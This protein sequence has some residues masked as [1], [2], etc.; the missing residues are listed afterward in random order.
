MVTKHIESPMMPTKHAK[1][2]LIA[3]GGFA[4]TGKTTIARRL[5]AD[6]GFPRLGSDDLGRM[7]G[8]SEG[9]RDASAVDAYWIAYDVLFSLCEEF[10][11][12]GV[13]T[14][15]DITL[16]WAF[17]WQRLEAIRERHPEVLFQPI[18][19]RCPLDVCLDRIR[20]RHEA[21]PV[22]HSPPE[23]FTT[24]PKILAVWDF[25]EHL[26]RPEVRFVDAA[27]PFDAV[28]AEVIRCVTA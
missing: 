28:Y 5:S 24:R 1:P 13:S 22:H 14:I 10:L 7:I 16:G 11:R 18:I 9:I 20:Q 17:Q 19:L 2:V 21:A 23:L 4:G 6:L 27:R 8:A 12:A 25:L 15:V 3:L 26:S